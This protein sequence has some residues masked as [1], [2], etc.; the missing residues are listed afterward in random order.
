MKLRVLY[1][2]SLREALGPGGEIEVPDSVAD[3]AGLRAWLAGQGEPAATAL[4][5]GRNVRAALDQRLAL[6][7]TPL[8]AGAE[9][10]F[11]LPVTGG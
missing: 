10:A 9:V 1:F 7:E 11:F 3:I 6:P 5:A 8:A 2:A 4:G